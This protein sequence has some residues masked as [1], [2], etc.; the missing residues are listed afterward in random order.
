MKTGL[1]A[2]EETRRSAKKK[3]NFHDARLLAA[4]RDISPEVA[5][6]GKTS[7]GSA[8]ENSVSSQEAPATLLG[9]AVG[10]VFVT[11]RTSVHV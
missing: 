6:N 1:P 2:G 11:S 10:G 4:L 5:R 8:P 7:F 9:H 3:L